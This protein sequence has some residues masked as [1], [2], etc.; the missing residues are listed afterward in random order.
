MKDIEQA[1]LNQ[2]KK[3]LISF[4]FVIHNK[5]DMPEEYIP[6]WKGSHKITVAEFYGG[7]IEE[8]VHN[9]KITLN[10]K[11]IDIKKIVDLKYEYDNRRITVSLNFNLPA[12]IIETENIIKYYI[13]DMDKNK[14]SAKILLSDFDIFICRIFGYSFMK[15]YLTRKLEKKEYQINRILSVLANT[16]KDNIF[17]NLNLVQA[18]KNPIDFSFWNRINDEIALQSIKNELL[19]YQKKS[20]ENNNVI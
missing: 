4:E 17:N 12:L 18:K 9:T 19:Y 20:G 3:P 15:K 8:A 11:E 1:L 14:N 5:K 16:L 13:E 10:E 6:E 7:I 2:L